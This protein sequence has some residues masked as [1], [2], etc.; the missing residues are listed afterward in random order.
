MIVLCYIYMMW[1]KDLRDS[2]DA[3][4]LESVECLLPTVPHTKASTSYILKA[5]K[6]LPVTKHHSEDQFGNSVGI[7][8]GRVHGNNTLGLASFQINVVIASVLST[9]RN[10]LLDRLINLSEGL[11]VL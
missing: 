5:R 2:V 7:L 1:Q 9:S 11:T 8:A 6:H 3:Y 10:I 4:H